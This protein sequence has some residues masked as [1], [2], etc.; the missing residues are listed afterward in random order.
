MRVYAATLRVVYWAE[1]GGVR[2]QLAVVFS[3][4]HAFFPS[5]KWLTSKNN[6]PISARLVA[7]SALNYAYNTKPVP[8]LPVTLPQSS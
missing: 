4:T 7:I 2:Q 6:V 3:M 1:D 8:P 5:V